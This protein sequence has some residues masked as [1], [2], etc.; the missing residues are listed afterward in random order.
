MAF[1]HQDIYLSSSSDWHITT[2]PQI[3]ILCDLAHIT[4]IIIIIIQCNDFCCANAQG[5]RRGSFQER[6]YTQKLQCLHSK[7]TIPSFKSSQICAAD[8][9]PN[10]STR[11]S[12]QTYTVH[13]TTINWRLR[14]RTP[15]LGTGPGE[16]CEQCGG[17]PAEVIN[18]KATVIYCRYCNVVSFGDSARWLGW[19]WK[20]SL[21]ESDVV[22]NKPVEPII[23][24]Y[25][26]TDIR[27]SW[28]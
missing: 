20:F 8:H 10:S 18:A 6:P 23:T 25:R 9:H 26:K 21:R 19:R 15:R 13:R 11:P 5:I 7:F 17:R 27:S 12:K 2:P 3:H 24:N 16:E 1:K 22:V 28:P 14:S 4:K